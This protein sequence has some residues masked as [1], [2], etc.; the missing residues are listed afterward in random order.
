MKLNLN[1][2]W[3]VVACQLNTTWLRE[4]IFKEFQYNI[5]GDKYSIDWADLTYPQFQGGF[6]KSKTG[7]LS[8]DLNT[9]PNQVNLIADEGPFAGKTFEGILEL[10]E[11]DLLLANFAFPGN[12]RPKVFNAKKGEVFEVWQRVG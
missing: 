9:K 11:N 3:K 1:G 10:I 2:S 7:K 4:S 12:P 8:F 6:P 5:D